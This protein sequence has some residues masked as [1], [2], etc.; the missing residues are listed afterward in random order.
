MRKSWMIVTGFVI[1]GVWACV[2]EEQ[3][4]AQDSSQMSS[5]FSL[6][7]SSK[8][9]SWNLNL[10]PNPIQKQI[11]I[12]AEFIA[13]G[14]D[15][16]HI[17]VS[18]YFA[19]IDGRN[20][21]SAIYRYFSDANIMTHTDELIID[22][23]KPNKLDIT[24]SGGKLSIVLNGK[25]FSF[26]S[27]Y[28]P[29]IDKIGVTLPTESVFTK[30]EAYGV[31]T[32]LFPKS[33]R[34]KEFTHGMA[35]GFAAAEVQAVCDKKWLAKAIKAIADL[36][37][38]RLYWI[39]YGGLDHGF[40]EPVGDYFIYVDKDV[41]KTFASIGKNP[42]ELATK[43]A[44]ENGMEIYAEIK[45]FDMCVMGLTFPTGSELAQKFGKLDVLG[46]VVY[47]G[48]AFP[49]T[50]PE[51]LMRRRS[52]EKQLDPVEKIV[53]QGNNKQVKLPDNI[54]VWVSKDNW[55]YKKYDKPYSMDKSD[56]RIVIK[57]LEIGEK[58]MAVSVPDNQ[59]ER[60]IENT[61]DNLVK[62]Y[63]IRG[64]QVSFTY[65]LSPRSHPFAAGPNCKPGGVFRE[66]GFAF[67]SGDLGMP[68]LC[69]S[70]SYVTNSFYALDNSYGVLGIAIGQNQF[71]PGTMEPA[72]PKARQ[73][74]LDMISEALDYGIDGVD[75]RIM[76]HTNILEWGQ[77]GFNPPI[78]EEYKKR[79]GVDILTQ[80]Y[81]K[82]K[83]RTLRGEYYTQFLREVKQLTKKRDKKLQ[84]HLF[85]MIEG[86][87]DTPTLAEIHFDWRQWLDEGI[88]DAVTYK[89]F[90]AESYATHFG[91]ELI[92][93]CNAKNIPIYWCSS[94]S[95]GAR[96][97][98][99]DGAVLYEFITYFKTQPD[100]E[101]VP[102]DPGA[103]AWFQKIAE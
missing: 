52:V 79:Y 25:S 45:P 21:Y 85:E 83:L 18:P 39:Y 92:A 62:V 82:E 43:Y 20:H 17:T 84:L 65:G 80:D 34:A 96:N 63:D 75:L 33:P 76:G 68:T 32:D 44:H 77:Y 48:M 61:L 37:V 14:Q 38:K 9:E 54:E 41:A 78:V 91:R 89:F 13:K 10:Y 1:C 53:I 51:L 16:L 19:R 71:I 101:V 58:F 22:R 46:G 60:T 26:S 70:A 97:A 7:P 30:L 88:P 50:H 66:D 35:M 103:K 99:L 40:W 24:Y 55:K 67:D 81:D 4:Y 12:E 8:L 93:K 23:D 64:K 36:G 102:R 69:L 27:K 28:D 47:P 5:L 31:K 95:Q 42:L 6:D 87:A 56:G 2:L 15:S 73:Y 74:W 100:G 90:N 59:K 94:A 3:A 72:E 49:L 29:T 98:G 86:S 57:G 11:K